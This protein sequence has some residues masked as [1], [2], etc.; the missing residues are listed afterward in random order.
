MFFY[1][2]KTLPQICVPRKMSDMMIY[3]MMQNQQKECEAKIA[4]LQA[5]LNKKKSPAKKKQAQKKKSNKPKYTVA[6]KISWYSGSPAADAR[7]AK[8]VDGM[9]RNG[10]IPA[11]ETAAE[12]FNGPVY[13]AQQ[14]N[15][16]KGKGKGKTGGAPPVSSQSG[17]QTGLTTTNIGNQS[18]SQTSPTALGILSNIP[19]PI[20]AAVPWR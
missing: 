17:V 5:A 2:S 8:K 15:K 16:G 14:A 12:F 3:M 7:W 10:V 9:V 20:N 19:P 18:A 11:F 1:K 6:Q 4:R 13:A